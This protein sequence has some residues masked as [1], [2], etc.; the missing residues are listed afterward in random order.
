VGGFL[1]V[2]YVIQEG[3]HPEVA[4][5]ES[6][7]L[8]SWFA[9]S[10]SFLRQFSSS[11]RLR[12]PRD[13]SVSPRSHNAHLQP[14]SVPSFRGQVARTNPLPCFADAVKHP[15]IGKHIIVC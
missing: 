3:S 11:S 8:M 14:G 9:C 10:R 7:S 1:V 12:F 15:E 13:L 5:L 6:E 2:D 4:C